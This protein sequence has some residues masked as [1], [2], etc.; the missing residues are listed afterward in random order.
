[1]WR[2]S[3]GPPTTSPSWYTQNDRS[4]F[5]VTD[6]SFWRRLPAPALRGLTNNRSPAAAASSFMRSKLATGR[7]TSPRTSMTSGTGASARATSR[8]GTTAI[9]ATL[10]V[11][12]SPV[13]P[14][15]R[16]AAWT[17]RPPS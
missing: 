10:A 9:V 1:M 12:S 2:A 11:T 13:R 14:S 8:L 3:G 7:Y 17:Y 4:R 6:G 15:P 5:A 16:V